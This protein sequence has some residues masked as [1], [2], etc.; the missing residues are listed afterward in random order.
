MV[1]LLSDLPGS[2]L[3][4]LEDRDV[5][6]VFR[7]VSPLLTQCLAHGGHSVPEDDLEDKLAGAQKVRM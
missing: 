4:G 6:V 7:F 5:L 1:Y 2:S 3:L